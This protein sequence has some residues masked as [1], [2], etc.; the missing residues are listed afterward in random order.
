MFFDTWS[1]LG[2]TAIVDV[3]AYLTLVLLLRVSGKARSR[4]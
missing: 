2:R 1:T 4:R 3:L